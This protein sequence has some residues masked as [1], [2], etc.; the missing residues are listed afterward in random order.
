MVM[1][2]P[3][4]PPD[5]FQR[6]AD[7]LAVITALVGSLSTIYTVLVDLTR[8]RNR[9]KEHSPLKFLRVQ[10]QPVEL[11]DWQRRKTIY[12]TI[13]IGLLVVSPIA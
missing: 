2:I 10:H 9:P 13:A 12:L 7:T 6:V 1:L 4:S 5:P 8:N 3:S 11:Q